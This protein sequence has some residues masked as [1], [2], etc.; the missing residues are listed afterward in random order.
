MLGL[1]LMDITS[2]AAGTHVQGAELQHSAIQATWDV[3]EAAT[4][5]ESSHF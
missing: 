1:T 4:P 3:P 5:D 2:E